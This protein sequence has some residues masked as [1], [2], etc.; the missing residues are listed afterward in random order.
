MTKCK[1][2]GGNDYIRCH[3]CG[4]EYD[5][6][7]QE[8]PPCPRQYTVKKLLED[9]QISIMGCL[10]ATKDDLPPS[11][12]PLVAKIREQL[13]AKGIDPATVYPLSISDGDPPDAPISITMV[14]DYVANQ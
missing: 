8:R 4:L 1:W 13:I 7:R 10:N 3:T 11:V 9:W 6:R 2:G 14:F 12:E 5:Y